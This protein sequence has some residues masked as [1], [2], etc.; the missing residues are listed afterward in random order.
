MARQIGNAVPVP[1]AEAFG[2][3][4]VKHVKNLEINDG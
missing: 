3:H 2:R 1:V 4:F